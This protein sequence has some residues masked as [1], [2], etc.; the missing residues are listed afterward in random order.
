M[1]IQDHIDRAIA[2]GGATFEVS[3]RTNKLTLSVKEGSE[4]I[5]ILDQLFGS[6][7]LSLVP[8]AIIRGSDAIPSIEVGGYHISPS[9]FQHDKRIKDGYHIYQFDYVT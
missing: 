2:S 9:V 3:E 8:S 5:V 7:R 6:A 4:L 1:E